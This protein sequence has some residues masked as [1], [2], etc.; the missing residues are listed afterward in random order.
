MAKISFC[1]LWNCCSDCYTIFHRSWIWIP[2]DFSCK[3]KLFGEMGLTQIDP[4]GVF[5]MSLKEFVWCHYRFHMY[6]LTLYLYVH[7]NSPATDSSIN[8]QIHSSFFIAHFQPPLSPLGPVIT[9]WKS[10]NLMISEDL[11]AIRTCFRVAFKFGSHLHGH[12]LKLPAK[13]SSQ[14]RYLIQFRIS[15]IQIS[16]NKNSDGFLKQ[17]VQPNFTN[18]L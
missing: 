2:L 7:S 3:W 15:Q 9:S 14:T 10:S 11:K 13:F 18:T 17:D 1:S 12:T 16:F 4:I 8:C 6:C 5:V